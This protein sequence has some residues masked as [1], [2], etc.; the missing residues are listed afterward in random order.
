MSDLQVQLKEMYVHFVTCMAWLH[1]LTAQPSR[2]TPESNTLQPN[3][4][5][6]VPRTL[7]CGA[8]RAG[9]DNEVPET[10]SSRVVEI[11]YL[12]SCLMQH[13]LNTTQLRRQYIV[14]CDNMKM[15]WQV[16]HSDKV[17]S[18]SVESAVISAVRGKKH[19]VPN[20]PHYG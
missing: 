14:S 4:E 3:P 17:R 20:F 9:G 6:T 16:C 5:P 10:A 11:V 19:T 12:C 13:L 2:S 15:A 18:H 8:L 7:R 1:P